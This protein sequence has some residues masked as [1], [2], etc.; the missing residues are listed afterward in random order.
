MQEVQARVL[1]GLHGCVYF[2]AGSALLDPDYFPGPWSD[3][4]TQWYSCNRYDDKAAID[5]RDQQSKSRISL[6]RYLH[7]SNPFFSDCLI[8]NAHLDIVL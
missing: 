3:H 2:L 4:G 8:Q 7:V 6:E 5:A 1:L